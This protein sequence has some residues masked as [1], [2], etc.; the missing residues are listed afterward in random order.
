MDQVKKNGVPIR[1]NNERWL[2]ITELFTGTF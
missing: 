1:L 2:H